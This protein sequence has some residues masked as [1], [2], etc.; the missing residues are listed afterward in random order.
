MANVEI[1]PGW[2]KTG[3]RKEL[4]AGTHYGHGIDFNGMGC[5]N[6][7]EGKS[8][9]W[10]EN[11]DG[12][13]VTSQEFWGPA[14][15]PEF[16]HL[17]NKNPGRLIIKD[18]GLTER[19]MLKVSHCHW[20]GGGHIWINICLPP[21][22]YNV[23]DGYCPDDWIQGVHIPP[24]CKVTL[25]DNTDES[26]GFIELTGN[27]PDFHHSYDLNSFN[28]ANRVS[29]VHIEP[30]EWEAAGVRVDPDSIVMD[31]YDE[32]ASTV[33]LHNNG[34]SDAT[35]SDSISYQSTSEASQSWEVSGSISFTS[36][37]TLKGKFGPFAEVEQKFGVTV[38]VSAG[39]RRDSTSSS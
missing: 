9:Q 18:T 26:G 25:Y 31:D 23:S 11:V 32:V 22:E 19:D 2:W 38:E 13:G 8:L 17:G 21:G 24:N 27:N 12:T 6:I 39:L 29:R 10:V 36:E 33:E 28:F 16:Y 5:V 7:P 3:E 34:D 20:F 15:F 4:I 35:L 37:T 14:Y 30:D 1:W